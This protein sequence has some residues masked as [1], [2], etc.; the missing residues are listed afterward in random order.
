MEV[1][2][3]QILMSTGWKEPLTEFEFKVAF[4]TGLYSIDHVLEAMQAACSQ[5]IDLCYENAKINKNGC[6]EY[7]ENDDDDIY[8]GDCSAEI[9]MDSILNTINQVVNE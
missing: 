2:L 8:N 4:R 7:L 5:T 3:K 1:N 9:D 6:C